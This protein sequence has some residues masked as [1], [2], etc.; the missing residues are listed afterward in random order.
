[1]KIRPK[2][3][4]FWQW[5]RFRRF[6]QLVGE[7]RWMGAKITRRLLRAC[8]GCAAIHLAIDKYR[9]ENPPAVV[10]PWW[11]YTYRWI[12][13]GEYFEWREGDASNFRGMVA[14]DPARGAGAADPRVE[15]G[16]Q[17]G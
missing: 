14:G 15:N 2:H 13:Y 1:M 4:P 8:W 9:E 5:R 3:N 7:E 10:D 16:G 17:H 12:E 11:H 6:W